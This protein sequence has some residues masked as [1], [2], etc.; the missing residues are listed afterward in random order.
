MPSRLDEPARRM[1][2]SRA[3]FV[4]AALEGCRDSVRFA[5][6]NQEAHRALLHYMSEASSLHLNWARKF[7]C[8]ACASC[9]IWRRWWTA[10]L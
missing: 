4:H 9:T 10:K 2:R 5:A 1:L 8:K 6:L 3:S 7:D